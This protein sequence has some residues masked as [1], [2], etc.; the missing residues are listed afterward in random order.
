M[1]K[2]FIMHLGKMVQGALNIFRKKKPQYKVV[3]GKWTVQGQ[4]MD[5]KFSSLSNDSLIGQTVT[6]NEGEVLIDGKSFGKVLGIETISFDDVDDLCKKL[7]S[8]NIPVEFTAEINC[9]KDFHEK[10]ANTYKPLLPKL[11]KVPTL[12]VSSYASWGYDSIGVDLSQL[13]EKGIAHYF[14]TSTKS[15]EELMSE[16][17]ARHPEAEPWEDEEESSSIVVKNAT[18]AE[19]EDG[20]WTW[21]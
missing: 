12:I 1:W 2:K 16:Y 14:C 3:E 20:T 5:V 17:L 6:L 8:Y 15:I 7:D 4:P 9:E 13:E 10:L 11:I 18:L 21:V 19:W